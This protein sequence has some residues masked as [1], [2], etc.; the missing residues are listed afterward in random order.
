LSKKSLTLSK[1]KPLTIQANEKQEIAFFSPATEILYGGAAG[2]GKSLLLRL[3]AMYLAL[4][5]EGIQIYLFRRKLK[6]LVKNH[7]EGGLGFY[8]LFRH[9][10][11]KKIV[12]IDKVKKEITVKLPNWTMPS[13]IFLCHC[14]TEEHVRDYQGIEMH[15]LL[16]DEL[17]HF[18][19]T[20]YGFLRTRVRCTGIEIP[21]HLD[22]N[23]FPFILCGSNPSSIGHNW[24]KDSFVNFAPPYEIKRAPEEDGGM[25]RQYIP[26]SL[27][28]NKALLKS[29]PSYIHR[30]R[31]AGN[32][33]L[34]K[35][36]MDGDW[37][38]IDGGMFDDVWDASIHIVEPFEIPYSWYLD[39][40]LDWGSS[41]PFSV[42]FWAE[43]DGSTVYLKNGEARH[44]PRGTLFRIGEIYGCTSEPN[45]GLKIGSEDVAQLVLEYQKRSGLDFNVGV[46]D[47]SIFDNVDRSKPSIANSFL[48]KGVD[49][50]PANKSAGTRVLGIQLF[51]DMLKASINNAES[52]HFYVFNTCRS[53]IR[54][55]PVLPR[56][57]KKPDDID[58]HAE[59]H[60]FDETRY[61]ILDTKDAVK[62][63]K[64][65]R[66]L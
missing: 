65:K 7:L 29:D 52:P 30:L 53:F 54:T 26:A 19:K 41:R 57:D 4:E 43:S 38:I 24:V 42:G 5:V 3:V 46:A 56:D 63:H 25:L 60:I 61:R 47:S 28:D 33:K 59:D 20:I 22:K 66:G 6:D 17:T 64:I 14:Q 21:K 34:V 15:A 2:G 18:T 39:R 50:K 31:G 9:L 16:V 40:S 48:K 49:W 11:K 13:K 37:D 35:A 27:H 58:T 45:T 51:R 44:Y 12:K 23:K 36:L 8:S 10:V 55:V 1:S 32:D 62:A